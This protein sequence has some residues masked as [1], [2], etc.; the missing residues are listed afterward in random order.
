MA[1]PA[2]R[3]EDDMNDYT[4]MLMTT[5]RMNDRLREA[6]RMRQARL[7]TRIAPA[8]GSVLGRLLGQVRGSGSAD[9]TPLA[10]SP[11]EARAC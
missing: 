1:R 7:A 2:G 9:A 4:A 10:V 6:D 5:E 3:A 11:G 8:H